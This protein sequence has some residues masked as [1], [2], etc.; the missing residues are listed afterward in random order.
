MIVPSIDIQGGRT[1]QLVGGE[2]PAVEAG[3]PATW[4][5]RFAVAGELA[6]V[7]LDA[8]RGEGSNAA[9]IRALCRRARVRVGG[10]IRDLATARSWL[11][12][13]AQRIVLGTAA[14]PELLA[15]LPRDRVVVAL[16]E[17]AGEVVTHGWRRGSGMGL[18]ERV[19]ALRALCGGF[20]VTFVDREGR[21]GGTDLARAAEVVRRAGGTRVTIAGGVTAAAEVAALDRLGADAQVGM[22]LYTGRLD[23]ADAVAAPLR[24]DRADGLWP[25]VV[26]DEDGVA[27]GLAWSDAGSL[28]QAIA[29]RR[30]VYHSR[31]RGRWE[32]GATS[33]DW[34]EL[35]AVD[36]DCDRDALRFTVRQHGAG[37]CHRGCRTCW[38]DDRGLRRLGRRLAALRGAHDVDPASN[39]ARL[40]RD[41][42]LLA[43]KLREEAAEL[44]AADADVV[45]EGADVV[46]FLLLRLAAA[47][48]P[49]AAIDAELDRRELRVRRRACEA[50][51]SRA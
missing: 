5:Q 20:L 34:Q 15:Q 42:A 37:F 24:S 11:D 30:G 51:E 21:L 41:P 40:L 2:A 46:Y 45:A 33:G 9:A 38:G 19:E 14:V 13:G 32:K 8:A 18:F 12:A 28:R 17:K 44:A 10:G 47:G 4:L 23:L 31:S 3:D 7:D 22:A 1:V 39:S 25:T 26:V 48:V 43:A 29:S 16:D 35:L 6:V 27:L 50:K 36:L 49:L